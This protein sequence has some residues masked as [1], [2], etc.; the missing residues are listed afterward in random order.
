MEAK[1]VGLLGVR[2]L[3]DTTGFREQL[4]AKLKGIEK[5]ARIQVKA[6]LDGKDLARDVERTVKAVEKSARV[7][8]RAV[9]DDD[10]L[11]AGARRA[12]VE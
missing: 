4:L 7:T 9:L 1:E 11:L 5:R 3:P 6:V 2:A 8:L 10:G 12:F